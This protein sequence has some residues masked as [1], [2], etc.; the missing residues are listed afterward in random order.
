VTYEYHARIEFSNREVQVRPFLFD[1]LFAEGEPIDVGGH[2]CVVEGVR[3]GC[4][5]CGGVRHI[6]VTAA[7][8]QL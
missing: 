5:R 7:L 1:R 3:F 6:S 2:S 8:K 4:L